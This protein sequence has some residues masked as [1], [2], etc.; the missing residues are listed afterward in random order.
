MASSVRLLGFFFCVASTLLPT[1]AE[2]P[3]K[4][5]S[6]PPQVLPAEDTLTV[7]A[8]HPVLADLAQ[9]IGGQHV[10]VVSLLKVNG[11]LHAFEPSQEDLRQASKA[12][13]L[14]ASGKNLE[15]YLPKLKESLKKDTLLL[16]LGQSIPDV[17]VSAE[18]ASSACCPDHGP[19]CSHEEESSPHAPKEKALPSDPH[20][21]HSMANIRLAATQIE[22][23]LS[24]ELPQYAADFKKN[25]QALHEESYELQ[26][27]AKKEVLA[28]PPSQ[29]VLVTGH[30]AFGHLCQELG[31][32]Q[33]ALQGVARE[34]EGS[35]GRLAQIIK[36]M[37][38]DGLH[39]VFPEYQANPK[40]LS[41]IA[42]SLGA[43]L[44]PPLVSDGTAPHAHD[45]KSLYSYNVKT[46][47][48]ALKT[49]K[50]Q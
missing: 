46:L 39:V 22:K 44:A 48:D 25:T 47:T 45:F 8:L 31:L 18:N 11:N 17:Q 1:F 9:R 40:V 6:T 3:Q 36:Q 14:L 15:P 13:L 21:W 32:S 41:E 38:A 12:R 33:I 50:K 2:S 16:D 10:K 20:W 27:W 42:K 30:A 24:Q 43:T 4:T 49:K 5:P 28:I 35:A 34:D 26:R 7:A 29:R 37:R 19:S 23:A